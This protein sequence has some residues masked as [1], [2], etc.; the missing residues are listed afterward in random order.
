MEV[1]WSAGKYSRSVTLL[2]RKKRSGTLCRTFFLR[3]VAGIC[4]LHSPPYFLASEWV[5]M[6]YDGS[7]DSFCRLL[8]HQNPHI[9]IGILRK[10]MK[11]E[12]RI[13]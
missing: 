6:S 1:R 12:T 3:N 11:I 8:H 5:V 2:L 7:E 10:E 4:A 13:T 9:C